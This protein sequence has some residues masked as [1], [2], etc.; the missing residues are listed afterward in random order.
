MKIKSFFIILAI[1]LISISGV[2]R[3]SDHPDKGKKFPSLYKEGVVVNGNSS[4]WDN[5]L[6]SF[7][8]KAQLNYVIVNDSAAFYIC[9]RIA[10]ESEQMKVLR[11]GIDLRFNT[12]GKKKAEATLHYPIG[13]RTDM[14]G[15]TDPGYHR[16]RKTMQLMFL[17]QMQDMELNGFRSGVNGFQNIKSGK[18]GITASVNWDSTSVMVYEA[19][20]PFSA[21][22][23]DVHAANPLAVGIV[24]KGAVKPKQEHSEGMSDVADGGMQGGQGQ[25]G[26]HHGGGMGG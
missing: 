7:N 26:V 1:T 20:I 16:D 25:G 18:N 12:K 3:P 4:E 19:R 15:R 9:L 14:G 2:P 6:F 22:A 8:K 23:E 5:T 10:D 13:G 17:L 21:F 24:I 11:S